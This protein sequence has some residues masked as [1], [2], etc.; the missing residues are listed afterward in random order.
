MIP[1]RHVLP[2]LSILVPCLSATADTITIDGQRYENVLISKSAALYYVQL[3]DEGRTLSVA[4][5]K[6]DPDSVTI[7]EDP[8]YRDELKAKYERNR[9]MNESQE[10]VVVD[11]AFRVQES[12]PNQADVDA[13]LEA[14]GEGGDAVASNASLSPSAIEAGLAGFGIQF[15]DGP[16]KGGHPTRIARSRTGITIELVGPPDE[17]V[18]MTVKGQGTPQ[19]YT[20]MTSQMRMFVTQAA[21]NAVSQYNGLVTEAEQKGQATMN[22]GGLQFR[23]SRDENG[24]NVQFEFN[25]KAR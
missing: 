16:N 7:N 5:D 9:E 23:L 18:Q 14:G 20:M 2:A 11:P 3:P 8:Y 4:V 15:Q 19:E 13:L 21:P 24:P 6:V 12:T 22:A 25:V 1:A 10:P 17:L